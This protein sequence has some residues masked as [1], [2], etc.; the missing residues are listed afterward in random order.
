MRLR[1]GDGVFRQEGLLPDGVESVLRED[2]CGRGHTLAIH[3]LTL[4]E[5]KSCAAEGV[6]EDVN[7]LVD[8]DVAVFDNTH[9]GVYK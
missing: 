6:G 4:K 7:K 5:G 9:D 3:L 2:V 8:A 1:E